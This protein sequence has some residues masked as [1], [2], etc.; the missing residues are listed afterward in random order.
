MNSDC[1]VL[2]GSEEGELSSKVRQIELTKIHSNNEQV[3]REDVTD[4]APNHVWK[5]RTCP[6]LP[7]P[8]SNVIEKYSYTALTPIQQIETTNPAVQQ[9]SN[10]STD[11][12]E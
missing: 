5:V 7:N 4:S 9:D 3:P 11:S 1:P 10:E 8:G 2:D 12:S 6:I